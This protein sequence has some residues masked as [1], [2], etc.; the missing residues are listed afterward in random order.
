MEVIKLLR[1]WFAP[2]VFP[3]D[4]EKTRIAGLL[5]IITYIILGLVLLFSVP[6]LIM[7]PSLERILA[8]LILVGLGIGMIY[9]LRHGYVKLSGYL[10]SFALWLVITWITYAYSGGFSGSTMSS[11]FGIV[12]IAA[13]LLGGWAGA[14]FGFLSIAATGWMLY[15]Q[16]QGLAPPPPP[17]ANVYTLWMDF[18]VTMIGVAGLLGLAVSNLN[19]ALRRARRDE[20]E[21]AQKMIEVQKLAAEAA[22]ASDFKSRLIARVSHELRTPLGAILGM[23]EMLHYETYGPLSQSQKDITQRVIDN[24]KYLEIVF[25]ELLEQSQIESRRLSVKDVVFAPRT[26]IER[27]HANFL[28]AAN[29]LGLQ[30][31]C[32]IDPNLPQQ[33]VGD[34]TRIEQILSNLVSNA[35]KFTEVGGISLHACLVDETHWALEV[36]DSG[37]GVPPEARQYIFEPFRQVDESIAR[38]HGGVGLGLSI[39][40]Q[41]VQLLQGQIE[42]E[43]QVGQGSTFTI[44]LPLIAATEIT[45]DHQETQA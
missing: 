6:A 2:P 5:H 17:Q 15:A 34:P 10:L 38:L 12:M 20:K 19:Q 33:L 21:L 35:I 36:C 11:Y 26:V 18:S 4:E 31:D 9:L 13:L 37:I 41:L 27:V 25:G 45:L 1:K 16:I 3:E 32:E 8:E 28:Q 42:L 29:R 7:T 24:S 44:L 40:K 30:F 14:L 39:V 22:E 23:T 43:S